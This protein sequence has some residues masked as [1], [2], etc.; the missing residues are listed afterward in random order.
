MGKE[1]EMFVSCVLSVLE[2]VNNQL[3]RMTCSVGTSQPLPSPPCHCLLA[4]EQGSQVAGMEVIDGLSNT[5][6]H[7]PKPSWL[8]HC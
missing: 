2:D 8:S 7:S 3:D 4:S 5:D 6:F 1:Y